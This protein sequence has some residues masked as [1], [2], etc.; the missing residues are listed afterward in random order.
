MSKVEDNKRKKNLKDMKEK[1]SKSIL[2]F[3]LLIFIVFK[4]SIKCKISD[5]KILVL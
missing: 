2:M 1:T 4:K 3:F 5:K